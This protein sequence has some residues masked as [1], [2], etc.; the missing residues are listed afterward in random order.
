VFH[1]YRDGYCLIGYRLFAE[2]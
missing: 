2:G 1:N